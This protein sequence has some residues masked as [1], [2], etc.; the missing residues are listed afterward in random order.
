[1][2]IGAI[3]GLADTAIK[4]TMAIGNAIG[5]AVKQKKANKQLDKANAF[6]QSMFDKQYYQDEFNRSEVQRALNAQ[7]QF[8]EQ[9]ANMDNAANAVNGATPEVALAQQQ[10]RN[11]AM[12]QTI[13]GIAANTSAQKDAIMGNFQNAK[14]QYFNSKAA[15]YQNQATQQSQAS[16]NAATALEG[17][18]VAAGM[19]AIQGWMPK[20]DAAQ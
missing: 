5:A 12:A 16:A 3:A 6:N 17:K 4:G 2:A 14:N 11:N 20:K 18:S 10:A 7:Q 8:N 19:E 9:Q 15:S 13:S 1:M